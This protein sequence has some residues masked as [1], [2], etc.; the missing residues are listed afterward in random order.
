MRLVYL[1]LLLV[2]PLRASD[3]PYFSILS[4]DKG[5]WPAILSSIGL[6]AQPA[7]LARVFVVRAGAP[8]S[9]EWP[10]RVERGDLLILEGESSLADSFGFRRVPRRPVRV[11]S[12][13]DI[14][15]PELPI[16]W[17]KGLEL[18]S[19]RSRR[20]PRSSRANAGPAPMAAGF[21]RGSGAVLWVAAPPGEHG[22][23]RFPYL[24][25]RSAIWASTRPSAPTAVGLLRFRLSLARRSGLFRRALA[26]SRHRRIARGGVAQFSKPIRNRTRI[27]A[28]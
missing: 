21:R 19:I 26:Q 8:A 15:R 22:Y 5:A 27:S 6:Q 18:P 28:A 3:L 14:H 16:I 24:S 12:L 4:D 20:T 13:T 2:L 17:E 23:E 25:M 11:Q 1:I 7:S 10:G 9:P